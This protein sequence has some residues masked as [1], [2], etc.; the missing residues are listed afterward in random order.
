[1]ETDTVMGILAKNVDIIYKIKQ[2]PIQ[3][4]I[5]LFVNSYNSIPNLTEK[6]KKILDKYWPGA[7]TVVKNG[8]SYRMPNHHDVLQLLTIV[9]P[10]YSSSANISGEETIIDS[11]EAL[12]VF[13]NCDD[14]LLIIEGKNLTNTP[15]TVFDFDKFLCLREGMISSEDIINT[16][17][18]L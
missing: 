5:V 3:K 10:L 9:G 18:S 14:L 13:S 15:S 12:K 17:K 16:F 4:K 1:M 8:I 7:L 2:R 11:N 6:E